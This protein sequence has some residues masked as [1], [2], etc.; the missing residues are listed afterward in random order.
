MIAALIAAVLPGA[1][2]LVVAEDWPAIAEHC[3]P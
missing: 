3:G 2:R 1:P